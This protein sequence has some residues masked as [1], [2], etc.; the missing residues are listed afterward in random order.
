MLRIS[1][2]Q[3][4]LIASLAHILIN[5]VFAVLYLLQPGSIAG[6]SKSTTFAEAFFFSVQTMATIGYGQLAPG[7]TYA[8][9]LVTFETLIGTFFA[10]LLTGISF[11]KFAR[12]TA[13]ILFSHQCVIAPR[14]GVPHLM[15]RMANQRHN[16]IVEA[17]L[18]VTLMHSEKS[19]EGD[20]LRRPTEIALVRNVNRSFFLTWLAMHK[21]DESSPFSAKGVMDRL[22]DDGATLVLSVMGLDETSGQT[23]HARHTYGMHDIIANAKFVD[24]IDVLEDGTREVDYGKFH[25]T[26]D[27]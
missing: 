16:Q 5:A 11:A 9:L 18:T 27:L 24:V 22:S 14:N 17:Q 19:N 7:T 2:G 6:S 8:H 1:W 10:A 15:F 25:D 23:V 12:P 21:I 13:R 26:V 4:F 3:F 20:I